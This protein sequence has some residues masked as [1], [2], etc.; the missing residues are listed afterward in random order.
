M[1]RS[2]RWELSAT[3]CITLALMLLVLP[4]RWILAWAAAAA[5]HECCHALAVR[6]C[7]GKV[8]GVRVRGIGAEMSVTGIQ[9]GRE[10]ICALAGPL[11]ALMLLLF[12]RWFPATAVCAVFQSV[13]NLLPIYPMDGG[14]ALRCA[15]E[16]AAPHRRE[17]VCRWT[18]IG[19]LIL[20]WVGVIYACFILRLGIVPMVMAAVLYHRTQAGRSLIG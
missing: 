5:F 13:Y 6:L 12:A 2:I 14:R 3:A 16:M 19:T 20:I 4:L 18:A 7:G 8:I 11:G 10:L 9:G 17:K 1:G 15:M